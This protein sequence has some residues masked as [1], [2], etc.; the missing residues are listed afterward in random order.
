MPTIQANGIELYYERSGSGP[1]VLYISGTGGDLR[2]KPGVSDGPLP[3]RFDV[4]AYDQRGMGRAAKPDVPYSMADYADD[5]AGLMDA[6][7][8]DDARVIGVSFGGMVAQNLVARHP[9]RVE[10][11]VLCC[12]SPGGAG[13]ASYPLHE[14][15]DLEGEARASRMIPLLDTRKDSAWAAAHP[16]DYAQLLGLGSTDPFA[17]ETGHALGARR[18]IEARQGHDVWD[19][20][21]K[22]RC[23]VLVAG[24]RY[25]GVA[26]PETMKRMADRIP[27][28][29]FRLFEG[30]HQFMLEDPAAMPAII[31]FLEA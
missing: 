18:Q 5:A 26:L 21:A 30:G 24:G 1:R 8:W 7:G 3:A 22:V 29:Q 9:E 19:A 12:T 14:L 27:R 13:G 20:L 2:Q 17:H 15:G 23:P 10:R 16:Q 31:A 25:D 11:L 4:L 6:V 28:A